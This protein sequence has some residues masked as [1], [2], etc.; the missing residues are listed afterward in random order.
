MFKYLNMLDMVLTKGERAKTRTGVDVIKV[1]GHQ[2]RFSLSHRFP[3]LTTKKLSFH[4]ILTELLFF[5]HGKTDQKW[6]EERNCKIWKP[7]ATKEWCNSQG[8]QENDLGP[9]YGYQWRYFNAPYVDAWSEPDGGV[10]QLKAIIDTLLSDPNSRRMICSS[11]NPQQLNQMSLPPC[12]LLF[13]VST[14]NKDLYLH[15]YQ[16]SADLFIGVPYNIASYALLARMIAHVTG[17]K[18]KELIISWND[19]HL[20]VNHIEQAKLQLKRTPKPLPKL[21]IVGIEEGSG[22][23][24]LLS[25]TKDNFILCNYDPHPWIKAE[26]AV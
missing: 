8:R 5:I 23:E 14:I 24:G 26:V 7:W 22:M 13:Q 21:E 12:H 11:W 9:V 25:F 4:N 3:L 17:F 15:L 1:I 2:E 10:D 6:M 19:L 16:R 20:Y 18:A